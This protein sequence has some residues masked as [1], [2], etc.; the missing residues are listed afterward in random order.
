M[1][2]I[3]AQFRFDRLYP[4]LRSCPNLPR[5]T[6]YIIAGR[7]AHIITTPLQYSGNW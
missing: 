4:K 6:L 1:Y 3:F 5:P 2:E 7:N